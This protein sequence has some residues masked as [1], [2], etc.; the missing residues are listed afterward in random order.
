[1][2]RYYIFFALLVVLAGAVA[3]AQTTL[4]RGYMADENKQSDLRSF[5][6]M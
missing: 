6:M 1:L 4:S 3:I 5:R 2:K